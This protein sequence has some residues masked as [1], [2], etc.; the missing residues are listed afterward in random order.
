MSELQQFGRE[1]YFISN[2][3]RR[4]I[5]GFVAGD[6]KETRI[7]LCLLHALNSFG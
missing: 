1:V 5:D 3:I 7:L 4:M 2:D 6:Q